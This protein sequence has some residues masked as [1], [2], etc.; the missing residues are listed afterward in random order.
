MTSELGDHHASH[1]IDGDLSSVWLSESGDDAVLEFRFDR[2]VIVK[3]VEFVFI[4][5]GDH[6]DDA[7]AIRRVEMRF[8]DAKPI[9]LE[10]AGGPGPHRLAFTSRVA[11]AVVV[12]V[13]ATTA[14]SSGLDMASIG[15][16]EVRFFGVK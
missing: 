9:T 1:L 3:E 12:E 8:D 5:E 10:L 11:S 14:P 4:T 6:A 2:P 13:L 7:T 15:L 16:S